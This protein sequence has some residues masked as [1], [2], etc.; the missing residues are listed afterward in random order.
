MP[1]TAQI[2]MNPNHRRGVS[3][4]LRLLDE[5]LCRFEEWGLGRE[6]VSVLYRERN[7]L[8]PTQRARILALVREL[9]EQLQ[10]F[11]RDMGLRVTVQSAESDIW[12][13]CSGVWENLVELESSYLRRYG[14]VSPELATYMDTNVPALIEGVEAILATVTSRPPDRDAGGGNN[15]PEGRNETPA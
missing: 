9:R 11:R 15:A 1:K 14:K 4:T 5:M 3:A 8:T 2:A 12:G 13:G 10:A 6:K 7:N